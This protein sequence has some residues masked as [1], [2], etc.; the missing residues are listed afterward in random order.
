VAPD[1]GDPHGPD[2]PRGARPALAARRALVAPERAALRRADRP[3]QEGDGAEVRRCAAP[4][5]AA[6]LRGAAP[7][8]R[9]ERSLAPALRSALR[10][11][12]A[13]AAAADGEPRD[14]RGPHAP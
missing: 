1:A 13:R 6:R 12:T 14:G 4:S 8:A 10:E 2:R 9:R 11:A 5:V 3:Q 7:S